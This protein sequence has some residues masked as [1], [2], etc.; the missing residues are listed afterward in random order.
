M[1][2]KTLLS[3]QK[4]I[5]KCKEKLAQLEPAIANNVSL[6]KI[7]N[8]TLIKKAVLMKKYKKIRFKP[9]LKEKLKKILSVHKREK[10][11]CDYFK[12]SEC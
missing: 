5:A 1:D 11:I 7:Y 8:K 9:T 2:K 4:E 12:T 10:L 3:L 6:Q